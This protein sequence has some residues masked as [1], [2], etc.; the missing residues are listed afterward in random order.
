[1][2]QNTID[3]WMDIQLT[4]TPAKTKKTDK[5]KSA[6]PKATKEIK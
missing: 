1:M 5:T 6:K 2:D 4:V 3:R